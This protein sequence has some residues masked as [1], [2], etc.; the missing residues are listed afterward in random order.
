MRLEFI[1]RVRENDI[2]GKNIFTNDG[3]ILLRAG[4]KLTNQY[5]KKLTELGVLYLYIEDDNLEDIQV[6]DKHLQEI[7]QVTIKRMNEILNNVHQCRNKKAKDSLK[8]IDNLMEY[9]ICDGDINKSLYDIKTYDNYTYV[10]CVDTAIMSGFLG[11]NLNLKEYELKELGKGS[12]LHDIGKTKISSE[13]INKKGSLTEEEFREIKMHPIYGKNILK[14]CFAISD[15]ILDVVEQHHERIDGTGYPYGLKGNSITKYG[16]IACICDVYDALSS[17][18]SYR[19]KAAPNDAYEFILSQGGSMFDINI[20]NTFKETFAI[21][22]LG[23][24]VVLSDGTEGYIVRQNKGFPDRPV[25]R[26]IYDVLTKKPIPY[27]EID[28]LK[29]LDVTI[30]SVV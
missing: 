24:C 9:I 3:G 22:P 16:K 6:E 21:Y 1:N 12:I 14:K 19:K 15:I 8:V 7:K 4:V 20:V 13:I 2:L 27:Y 10:H 11:L 25:I 28:L 5:I 30:T 23:C 29:K 17:D 26:V 18:R